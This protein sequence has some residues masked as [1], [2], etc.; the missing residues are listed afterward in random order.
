MTDKITL[1][2]AVV[3]QVLNDVCG[4]KLCEVNS[5]SSLAEARRLLDKATTAL[6]AALARGAAL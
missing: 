4:A 3:E 2:R 6:R 5:M 1:D